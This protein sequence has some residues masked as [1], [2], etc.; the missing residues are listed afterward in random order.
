MHKTHPAW[1]VMNITVISLVLFRFYTQSWGV[2][3]WRNNYTNLVQVY[4]VLSSHRPAGGQ[5][6]WTATAC[7]LISHYLTGAPAL[8]TIKVPNLFKYLH[9]FSLLPQSATLDQNGSIPFSWHVTKHVPLLH[10]CYCDLRSVWLPVSSPL[11]L[12]E[13]VK[14]L[15]PVPVTMSCSDETGQF[16]SIADFLVSKGLALRK[17]KPRS[18][19]H[20]GAACREYQ[21][22]LA[23]PV[24]DLLSEPLP[25][26]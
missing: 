11:L 13:E 7:D 19:I 10:L 17:R 9:S 24:L 3:V 8:M 23:V 2:Q 18:V 25:V 5:S 21:I 1:L 6:T 16:V 15:C 20:K 14:D 22:K 4:F 26:I 12:Q